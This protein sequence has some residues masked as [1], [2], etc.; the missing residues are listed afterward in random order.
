MGI[1]SREVS[2]DIAEDIIFKGLTVQGIVGRRLYDT[3]YTM[4]ALLANGTLDVSPILTHQLPFEEF[5][6][7]MELMRS[8]QCGKVVL[9]L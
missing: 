1:P 3:W 5:E 9:R 4:K 2:L 7:G 6:T 8:G